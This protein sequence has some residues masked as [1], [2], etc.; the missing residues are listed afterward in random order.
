MHIVDDLVVLDLQGYDSEGLQ[1]FADL[2]EEGALH[3]G[4][5]AQEI[6]Q[7]CIG[8]VLHVVDIDT[9]HLTVVQFVVQGKHYDDFGFLE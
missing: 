1:P 3:L 8:P 7:N 5:P 4:R 9:F 2:E 6:P